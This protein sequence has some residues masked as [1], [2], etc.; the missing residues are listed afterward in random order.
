MELL[1]KGDV[2][3][4]PNEMTVK[5]YQTFSKDKEKYADFKEILALYTGIPVSELKNLPYRT[6][7]LLNGYLGSE[8]INQKEVNI[9]LWF[10]YNGIE[11]GL[12]NDWTKLS[13]GAWIDLEV[14]GSGDV[15]DNIHKILAVM[16]RPITKR[17]GNNYTIEPYDSETVETRANT[18]LD[19]PIG[20]WLGCA[21]FFFQVANSSIKGLRDSLEQKVKMQKL[22]MKGMKILPKWVQKKL[23]PD[24]ILL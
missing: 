18:F 10:T 15:T 22:A 21:S 4:V 19:L 3:K 17:D 8:L 23:P 16:Y 20:I 12:E 6:I 13:W 24:S 2:I 1:Y 9:S 11:Y 5:M 7:S 14:Y